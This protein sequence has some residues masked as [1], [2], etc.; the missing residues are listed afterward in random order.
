MISKQPI[1]NDILE[2]EIGIKK[3]GHRERI[4]NKLIEEGK[5]LGSKFNFDFN[6]EFINDIFNKIDIKKNV[7]DIN[8]KV[9]QI[10]EDCI[11]F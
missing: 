3:L 11:I 7:E 1:N 6:F 5:K 4:M 9:G 2:N 10:K 8:K